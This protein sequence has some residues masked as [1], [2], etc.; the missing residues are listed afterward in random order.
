MLPGRSLTQKFLAFV[1]V[2]WAGYYRFFV[3]ETPKVRCKRTHWNMQILEKANVA[4]MEYW[5]IFHS[6][7]RHL[8]TILW[9]D[10]SGLHMSFAPTIYFRREELKGDDGNVIML[11]WFDHEGP[12]LSDDSPIIVL[13]HGIAGDSSSPYLQR[14]ASLSHKVGWRC[15]SYHYWRLDWIE[16]RDMEIAVNHIA[17]SYPKAPICGVGF[18]AGCHKLTRYLQ[19]AGALSPM[20]CAVTVSGVLDLLACYEDVFGNEN[21]LYKM[22]MDCQLITLV[23]RHC[24]YD[25]TIPKSVKAKMLQ[26]SKDEANCGKAL[27]DKFHWYYLN[28][29]KR[30]GGWGDEDP[31]FEKV[32][33]D[34]VGREYKFATDP[35]IVDHYS[36]KANAHMDKI[37]VTTLMMH[38]FDD[39]IVTSASVDWDKVVAN[40]NIIVAQ[41]KRGGHVG[42]IEGATPLGPTFAD[43]V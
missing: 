12:P 14:F 35:K 26:A 33:P 32:C 6:Y 37:E 5:P 4:K 11:D 16:G 30:I 25:N 19:I 29:E 41:T 39:P 8:M 15:V 43:R 10:V 34:I 27:Y 31:A 23:E 24:K 28:C 38:S 22:W 9:A 13:V 40:K 42:Y 21:R 20:V 2:A 7:N 18:S 17:K 3:V 1:V 36:Y